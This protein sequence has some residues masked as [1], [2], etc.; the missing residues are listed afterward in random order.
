[1]LETLKKHWIAFTL[2]G[3]VILAYFYIRRSSSGAQSQTA[4][5]LPYYYP[6]QSAAANNVGQ[7]IPNPSSSGV[8][9]LVP[10]TIPYNSP[11]TQTVLAPAPQSVTLSTTNPFSSSPIPA[12]NAKDNSA[13]QVTLSVATSPGGLAAL[14]YANL[15]LDQPN[16]EQTAA[17][18]YANECKLNPN[19][20][21]CQVAVLTGEIG[22]GVETPASVALNAA[23]FCEQNYANAS[24]FG[25]AT[26]P[27]CQG[28]TP[29]PGLIASILR[30]T[31]GTPAPPTATGPGFA[32]GNLP[33]N[34]NTLTRDQQ[35]AYLATGIVPTS[36]ITQNPTPTQ[37]PIQTPQI[38][39][40][41]GQIP[42]GYLDSGMPFGCHDASTDSGTLDLAR[43][44]ASSTGRTPR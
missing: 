11:S 22:T 38:Q 27:S 19:S 1:M 16:Y 39:C 12:L 41:N 30:N 18:K 3:G 28:T 4:Q 29:T 17:S 8:P 6:T 44:L 31:V 13:A 25:T 36:V 37:T 9:A 23:N 5:T 33:P 20:P 7:V 26:D 14:P 40:P 42:I 35:S 43:R 24:I 32:V 10:Q 34:W 15:Y 2:L 21:A